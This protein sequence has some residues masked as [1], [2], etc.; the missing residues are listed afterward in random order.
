[1]LTRQ[2][3]QRALERIEK[4]YRDRLVMSVQ[5]VANERRGIGISAAQQTQK[6]L[7]AH[8]R[9]ARQTQRRNEHRAEHVLAGQTCAEHGV[10]TI[11]QLEPL[12]VEPIEPARQHRMNQ[13]F[14]A[15]E[16]I[17]DRRQID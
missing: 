12:L 13:R 10:E 5:K 17:V 11:E 6:G 3:R 1:F 4:T 16:V 2:M 14:L 9:V 15:A 7:A 8:S